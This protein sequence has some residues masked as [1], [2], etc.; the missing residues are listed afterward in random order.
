LSSAA[1]DAEVQAGSGNSSVVMMRSRLSLS[2]TTEDAKVATTV[3]SIATGSPWPSKLLSGNN[4]AKASSR[5]MVVEAAV[6]SR[7]K[8]GSVAANGRLHRC[9]SCI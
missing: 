7:T 1:S 8:P 3:P 4:T 9:T 5:V 6:R 2:R